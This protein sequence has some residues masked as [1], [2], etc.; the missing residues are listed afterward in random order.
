[1]LVI[2]SFLPKGGFLLEVNYFHLKFLCLAFVQ[3]F[4]ITELV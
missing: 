1:M 3:V 2:N 4:F